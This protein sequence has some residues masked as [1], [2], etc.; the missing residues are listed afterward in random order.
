MIAVRNLVRDYGPIR[1]LADVSFTVERGQVVGLLG[2]NGAGKTTCMKILTGFLAATSGEVAIDGRDIVEHGV[3]VRRRLGYLPENA[4]VYQDMRARDYLRF[5]ARVR[6]IAPARVDERIAAVAATVGITAVLDQDIGTLSKGYRQRV[7]LAQAMIHDPEILIL[8]EPTSGLD[9]NQIV[10]IRELIK[11]LG[12]DRT[13]ILSTHNLPEVTATCNRI[14]LI[15]RG[16]LVADGTPAEIQA[17]H[18]G[19]NTYRLS[20]AATGDARPVADVLGA[21]PGVA[22][23]AALDAAA[24]GTTEWRVAGTG[25]ADLRAGLFGCAVQAGWTLLELRRERQDLETIFQRLTLS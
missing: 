7:G 19:G 10:E 1:A 17:R 16:R 6:G 24:P 8:D 4:P 2:P 15:H 9:P 22:S 23:V 25:D 13:V 12:R 20:L 21:I 11:E 14:L 3:E 5:V 18:G